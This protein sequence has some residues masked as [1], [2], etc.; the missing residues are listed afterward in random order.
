MILS[1]MLSCELLTAVL[2]CHAYVV[3]QPNV[4]QHPAD[5][6]SGEVVWVVQEA[7]EELKV[8][9]GLKKA[10]KAQRVTIN[11]AVCNADCLPSAQR[12]LWDMTCG[13]A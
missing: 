8:Y 6:I 5:R 13:S 10:A 11:M 1:T 12:L 4:C 2:L 9:E 7:R 3:V